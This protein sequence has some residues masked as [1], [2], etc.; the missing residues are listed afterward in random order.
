M[1]EYFPYLIS[2]HRNEKGNIVLG[3]SK[4]GFQKDRPRK[5]SDSIDREGILKN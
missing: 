2:K 3:F 1:N 5:D 4:N